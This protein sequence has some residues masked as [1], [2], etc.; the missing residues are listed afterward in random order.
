M[1]RLWVLL[2]F[3]LL[4][5][6]CAS[7]RF[8]KVDEPPSWLENGK[9]PQ[10]IAWVQAE[11]ERVKRDF[12]DH[13]DFK[14]V[15]DRVLDFYESGTRLPQGMIHGV[16]F[17]NLMQNTAHPRGLWRRVSTKIFR[18][19]GR[20]AAEHW[21]I[22]LDVDQLAVSQGKNWVFQNAICW[23]MQRCLLFLSNGGSENMEMLE[24]S[25]LEKKIVI[26]GF[27]LP[28]GR[29]RVAWLSGDQIV[30]ATKREDKWSIGQVRVWQRGQTLA[31]AE[32]VRGIE[33]DKAILTPLTQGLNPGQIFFIR[34]HSLFA[35]D[36]LLVT[37]DRHVFPV[38][39]PPTAQLLEV[40]AHRGYFFL[41]RPWPQ[42]GPQFT[43]GAVVA[44][45]WDNLVVPPELVWPGSEGQMVVGAKSLKSSLLLNV[46][47]NLKS[48]VIELRR[49]A[50][51]WAGET[52]GV[53]TLGNVTFIEGEGR[54]DE[55]WIVNDSYLIPTRLMSWRV[56]EKKFVVEA[57]SKP[58][59]ATENLER[60]SDEAV[61]EDGTRIPYVVIK[62]KNLPMGARTPALLNGY[63][64]LVFLGLETYLGAV[65]ATWL[66][67]GGIWAFAH[68]RGGLELGPDWTFAAHRENRA[69]AYADLHAVAKAIHQKGWSSPAHTGLFGNSKG[70]L[71]AAA[72]ATTYPADFGAAVLRVPILDLLNFSRWPNG[73]S[74]TDELG[75]PRS[76]SDRAFLKKHSPVQP[77]KVVGKLPAFLLL[78]ATDDDRVAPAHAR[79]MAWLLQR[80]DQKFYYFESE[81]GGH[82]LSNNPLQRAFR[83][84]LELTWLKRELS[85]P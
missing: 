53:P 64:S 46:L 79:R 75:E 62:P 59:F 68:V 1:S 29:H 85:K 81:E 49:S 20:P 63:G 44:V 39:V 76:E 36:Y 52:L 72:T 10:T 26:N 32:V 12:A 23:K 37:K 60:I 5:V 61:S 67:D 84:A 48:E 78:T 15:Y 4:M 9:A 2:S 40:D 11:N 80:N 45:S 35:Q 70:G 25:L 83:T 27:Q 55:A 82:A 3:L 56:G 8:G 33:L 74:W 38:K 66:K 22:L 42:A 18:H 69:K 43:A 30:L 14:G 13:A 41:R 19:H 16:H 54:P 31:E 57:K 6:A 34:K 71:L 51:G 7:F 58:S 24:F 47:K 17:Y 50:K 21:E 65:G 28:E 77:E 73:A